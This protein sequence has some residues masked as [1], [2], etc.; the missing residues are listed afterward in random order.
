[1]CAPCMYVCMYVCMDGWM[2]LVTSSYSGGQCYTREDGTEDE[3]NL[4]EIKREILKVI[5]YS[6]EDKQVM[7]QCINMALNLPD[8]SY[9]EKD[10]KYV[11]I[12]HF[13]FSV[14]HLGFA[15]RPTNKIKVVFCIEQHHIA[16]VSAFP[17]T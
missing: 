17:C 1:M 2:D 4:A 6:G 13:K 10:G 7:K 5:D 16:V 12:K 8:F 15:K 9:R 14:G 3:E 11:H